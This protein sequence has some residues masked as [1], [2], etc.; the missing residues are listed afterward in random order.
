MRRRFRLLALAFCLAFAPTAFAAW[1]TEVLVLNSAAV[2]IPDV[3]DAHG[4]VVQNRGPN[5]IYCAS[6]GETPVLTT[7]LEIKSGGSLSLWGT[8]F[9]L[10]CR[11]ATADQVTG[12]ATIVMGIP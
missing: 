8:N 12:A 6:H 2:S 11:A 9:R 3:P 7:S 4:V 10:K 1:T 5:S